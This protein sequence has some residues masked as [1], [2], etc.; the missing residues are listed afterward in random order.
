MS[1]FKHSIQACQTCSCISPP[2]R[3]WVAYLR[4]V[5]IYPTWPYHLGLS[6][7]PL[8]SLLLRLLGRD[9]LSS[10][11]ARHRPSPRPR[12]ILHHLATHL[13]LSAAL[14]VLLAIT[15]DCGR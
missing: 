10:E 1:Q 3:S 4:D 12:T 13:S 7:V 5:K 11:L 9:L 2:H 15:Y 6:W 14:P 8:A